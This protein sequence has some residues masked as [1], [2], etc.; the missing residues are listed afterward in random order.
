MHTHINFIIFVASNHFIIFVVIFTC[1]WNI[2]I[3]VAIIA[4]IA[5]WNVSALLDSTSNRCWFCKIIAL[6]RSSVDDDVAVVVLALLLI[7]SLGDFGGT[8]IWS[9]YFSQ[10]G[11]S[12]IPH[13]LPSITRSVH[14]LRC[15]TPYRL[16]LPFFSK[17]R[18]MEQWMSFHKS[19]SKGVFLVFE[20]SFVCWSTGYSRH[21]FLVEDEWLLFAKS[22]NYKIKFSSLKNA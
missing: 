18:M 15:F 19:F 21:L 17:S 1:C 16:R 5:F 22:I 2:D 10:Q 14:N 4:I 3:P 8:P 9:M 11:S 7:N 12:P 13:D 20:V 6:R